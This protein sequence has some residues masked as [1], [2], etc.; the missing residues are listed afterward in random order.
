LK[1]AIKKAYVRECVFVSLMF[2]FVFIRKMLCHSLCDN[3]EI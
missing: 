3:I 2:C 1:T